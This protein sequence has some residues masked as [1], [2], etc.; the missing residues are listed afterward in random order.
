[1]NFGI[2]PEGK[3]VVVKKVWGHERWLVNEEYCGKELHIN[4]GHN[5]SFH[6]HR[7]KSET[8]LVA[9]GKPEIQFI[10]PGQFPPFSLQPETWWVEF[11][12]LN[13][14]EQDLHI[15]R[16][17]NNCFVAKLKPGDV[18]NVPVGLVHTMKAKR[19]DVVLIEFSTH[20]EDSDSY[21]LIEGK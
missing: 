14:C 16:L 15:K 9:K 8:F 4:A 6:Y 18:F 10:H 17:W 5:C 19:K 2:V 20:H 12:T 11:E 3:L 7:K 1:M 13:R 21:R